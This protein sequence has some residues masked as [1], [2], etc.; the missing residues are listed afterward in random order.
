MDFTGAPERAELRR[1][2]DEVG[3][4]Q[5][6]KKPL[7]RGKS[8]QQEI[9]EVLASVVIPTKN[10]GDLFVKTLSR[11][12]SQELSGKFEIVVVDS[13]SSDST[14]ELARKAGARVEVILPDEFDHGNTRNL[15]VTLSRGEFLVFLS[16]D[17]V[18]EN[19]RWLSNLLSTLQRDVTV[20]GAYS[21]VVPHSDADFVTARLAAGDINFR[22]EPVRQQ[23]PGPVE[24]AALHPHEKRLLINFN[25]VSSAMRRS[26]WEELPLPRCEFAEDLLWGKAAIEAGYSI[27]FENQSVVEHSHRYG[28]GSLYRRAFVDGEANRRILDRECIRNLPDVFRTA[29]MVSRE[30]RQWILSQPGDEA[31]KKKAASEMWKV[32]LAQMWG[33]YRGGKKSGARLPTPVPVPRQRLRILFVLHGFPPQTRAGTE[34]YTVNL[35]KA[36]AREHDVFVF[37]R[38]EDQA[39]DNYSLSESEFDGLK[40]FRVVNNLNYHGIQETFSNRHVERGFVQVLDTV[41]PDVV[42]FQ[43]CLHTSVSLIEIA[44]GRGLPCL[45]TLHDYWFICPKVQ[46]IQTHGKVCSETRPGVGCVRCAANKTPLVRLGKFLAFAFYPFL[47]I[48]LR[49]YPRIIARF[50]FLEKRLILDLFALFRRRRTILRYLEDV[51]LMISP[52]PFLREK[53][54]QFGVDKRSII[55][56]RNGLDTGHLQ[57]VVREPSSGLRIA[58]MGSF[59]WYKGLDVLIKAFDRLA[60]DNVELHLYGDDRGNDDVRA[61]RDKV[62]TLS[63]KDSIIY[64]GPFR[65]QDLPAIY[66]QVDVLVVPSVWFENAPMVIFEAFAAGVPVI[67]SRLGGM[68]NFVHHEKNGLLFRAGDAEDLAKTLDRCLQEDGLLNRLAQAAPKVKSVEQNAAE[69]MVYYRQALGRRREPASFGEEQIPEFDIQA[70]RFARKE[71]AVD[72]QGEHFVLLRPNGSHPSQVTYHFSSRES[73]EY[74][75]E[76]CTILLAGESSVRLGGRVRVNGSSAGEIPEHGYSEGGALERRFRFDCELLEGKNVVEIDNGGADVKFGQCHVRL[77]R[78]LLFS[79]RTGDRVTA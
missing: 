20:G 71:G 5:G 32:R 68:A 8:S 7:R 22:D 69:M 18:P 29:W 75:L 46:L 72:L 66:A 1:R 27:V 77:A 40:V 33:L 47:L 78:V 3:V 62:S 12:Q 34:I 56:S 14:V 28:L 57:S 25:D 13:G 52:S 55:L 61:Y 65:S 45:L 54:L 70:C 51:D 30:D 11:I 41:R 10:A 31:Q 64:H 38:L 44:A 43:H 76:L 2:D 48:F 21:R 74:I 53:Y 42:H 67:A 16:Q 60:S 59:V 26:L 58:Y 4:K 6:V 37:H 19:N 17:A 39:S 9:E 73:G 50:P 49:L 79:T 24:Y 36:F 15:G 23:S 35:A 63:S